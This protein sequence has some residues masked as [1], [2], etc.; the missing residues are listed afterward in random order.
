MEDDFVTITKKEYKELL[1]RDEWLYYLDR[2]GVDNWGGYDY[3]LELKEED[4]AKSKQK[5]M[6]LFPEE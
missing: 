6:S 5:Q 4:D 2:A 1:K 3:A